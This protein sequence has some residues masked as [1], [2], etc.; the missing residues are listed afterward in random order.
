[1]EDNKAFPIEI[2][3]NFELPLSEFTIPECYKDDLSAVLIEQE[4]ILERIDKMAIEINTRIGEK[5]LVMICILKGSFKFFSDLLQKLTKIR[6]QC[7]W[8]IR[9]E[10]I[11]AKSY[12]DQISTGNVL[13]EGMDSLD[14]EGLKG[15][16][17]VLVDDIIDTGLTLSR[18]SEK[19]KEIV[20]PNGH[21][22][23]AIL[24][25]KR[26]TFVKAEFAFVDFVGFSV[27]DKL[28][29]FFRLYFA[30]SLFPKG[31]WYL[32]FPFSFI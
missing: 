9:V 10:F 1:M 4:K 27:P 22:W 7:S 2:E 21:I 30:W 20:G 19:F 5:P 6:L 11:R 31:K 14:N 18:L 24:I 29:S 15:A 26:T 17:V 16:Q 12:L 13:I 8:P 25:S 28:I 32:T 23:K 3:D